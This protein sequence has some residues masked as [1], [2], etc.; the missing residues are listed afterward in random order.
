MTIAF[1]QEKET[2]TERKYIKEAEFIQVGLCPQSWLALLYH[3]VQEG[4]NLTVHHYRFSRLIVSQSAFNFFFLK[5]S[6]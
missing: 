4:I 3:G 1:K 6:F 2:H 5:K